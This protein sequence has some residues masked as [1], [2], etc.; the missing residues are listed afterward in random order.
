MW[1]YF[2]FYF[3]VVYIHVFIALGLFFSVFNP[4]YGLETFFSIFIIE[5]FKHTQ[6][7]I[8]VMN[9]HVSIS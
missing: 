8:S 9:L 5:Y 4:F 7:E 2:L 6:K 1:M 3:F